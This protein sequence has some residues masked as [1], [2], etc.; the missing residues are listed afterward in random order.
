MTTPLPDNLSLISTLKETEERGGER[1]G[2]AGFHLDYILER[3]RE[4]NQMCC[5]CVWGGGGGEEEEG[6]KK[7]KKKRG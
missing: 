7:K 3:D 4:R 6:R 2:K 5:V 1:K